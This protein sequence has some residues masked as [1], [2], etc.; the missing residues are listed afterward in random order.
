MSNILKRTA[1]YET[2]GGKIRF[3]D[4]AMVN[5]ELGAM[6]EPFNANNRYA[7]DVQIPNFDYTDTMSMI[8][9]L[10]EV[11]S[12][13]MLTFLSAGGASPIHGGNLLP[14]TGR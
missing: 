1:F 3:Q 4:W 2:F 14:R 10:K 13:K 5:T 12:D 7:L 6:V 9:E 8:D 11:D